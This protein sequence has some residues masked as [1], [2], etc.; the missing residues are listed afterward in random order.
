LQLVPEEVY[1][2]RI[3][4][5]TKKSKGQGRGQLTE[6]T[7]IRCRFNLFIT[8]AEESKLP[9]N[10]IYPLYRLRWQ[11]ELQFYAQYIVM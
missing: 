11:I 5:K 2:K 6:E 8:N 4:E 10:Q 1:E 9:A 7:K 3:R